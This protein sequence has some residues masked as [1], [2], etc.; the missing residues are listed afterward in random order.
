MINQTW[1]HTFCTLVDV[2]HFTLTAQRLYMTQSGVSQHVKKLESQL[3]TELLLREGKSFTL[4]EAGIK[5][6]QQGQALLISLNKL[7][8]EIKKDDKYKGRI[9]IQSPGSIGLKLYPY[10]LTLQKKHPDLIIDY[11]FAPNTAIEKSIIEQQ[12]HLGLMTEISKSPSVNSKEISVEPLVLITPIDIIHVD[13]PI[14][15]QLGFISHPDASHH[16]QLL[17]SKNFVE[18]DHVNQFMHKGFSNQISLICEPISYGIGFTILPLYAA[19]SFSKQSKIRIHTLSVP[20]YESIYLS[21]C[22]KSIINE[23]TKFITS[24]IKDYLT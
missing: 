20:V 1:L 13:W 11:T 15:M 24:S 14:L 7:E 12:C 18:F 5:L 8:Q 9:K 2:G 22:N 19:H 16:G 21:F 6:Y 23:R 17:L 3:S 10:L 4:T